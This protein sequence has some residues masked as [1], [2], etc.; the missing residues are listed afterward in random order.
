VPLHVGVA[1]SRT[2]P[3]QFHATLAVCERRLP[4]ALTFWFSMTVRRDMAF[5]FMAR[6]AAP[7]AWARLVRIFGR[8][9]QEYSSLALHCA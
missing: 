9:P 3:A 1:L 7:A 2:S 5:W 6:S 8:A 4:A